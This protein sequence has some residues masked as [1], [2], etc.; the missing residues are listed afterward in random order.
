MW[1]MVGLALVWAAIGTAMIFCHIG[2]GGASG[3]V[4]FGSLVFGIIAA[5]AGARGWN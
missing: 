5:V 2:D 1:A 3:G 4:L